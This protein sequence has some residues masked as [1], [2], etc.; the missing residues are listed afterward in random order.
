[1][2]SNSK[3]YVM[4]LAAL[5]A[6]Q[7]A[8]EAFADQA[9]ISAETKKVIAEGHPS[10]GVGVVA[11]KNNATE[12]QKNNPVT[13]EKPAPPKSTVPV[14]IEDPN[15]PGVFVS[16]SELGYYLVE[17]NGDVLF[18]RETGNPVVLE[19]GKI[20]IDDKTANITVD[21]RSAL[22]RF[23][24]PKATWADPN[25]ELESKREKKKMKL[26]RLIDVVKS[27]GFKSAGFKRDTVYR[28]FIE[29]PKL[30]KT[31]IELG[32]VSFDKDGLGTGANSGDDFVMMYGR[33]GILYEK[34]GKTP[35]MTKE[36]HLI[37]NVPYILSDYY[38]GSKVSKW[39]SPPQKIKYANGEVRPIEPPK[40][41][42]RK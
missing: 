36:G 31:R 32:E 2:K 27:E 42:A 12:A 14:G 28:I 37:L 7:Y 13:I 17:G 22:L 20:P 40:I 24:D 4:F 15:Q 23:P 19:A 25:I 30:P 11:S 38:P 41:K 5:L 26:S 10:T 8:P 39:G 6:L 3:F 9:E 21:Q 18:D 16:P 35:L 29:N 34:D 33:E 1:M